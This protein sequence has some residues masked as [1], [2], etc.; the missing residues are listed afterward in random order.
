MARVNSCPSR[1]LP[2]PLPFP[3]LAR[4]VLAGSVR[5]AVPLV[6]GFDTAARVLI[7]GPPLRGS[8]PAWK[9]S[10]YQG[11]IRGPKVPQP[12]NPTLAPKNGANLGHPGLRGCG[13]SGRASHG[14]RIRTACG[15][16]GRPGFRTRPLRVQVR[17]PGGWGGRGGRRERRGNTRECL[18]GPQ[19]S[20]RRQARR[21]GGGR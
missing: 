14:L 6:E 10:N 4:S 8:L 11:H 12:R 7:H 18:R 21:G 5:R 16:Y 3:S 19:R 15:W 17:R 1:F 20:G 2:G 13:L 9:S